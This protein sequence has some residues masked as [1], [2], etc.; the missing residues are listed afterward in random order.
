MPEPQII[1]FKSDQYNLVGSLHLPEVPHPPFIIGC[2]GLFADRQSPKQ[3]A[4]AETCNRHGLAYLRFDHRGCGQS[5]GDFDTVTS[6]EG[7]CTDLYHAIRTMQRHPAIGPFRGLFG[8]SFGG[9]VVL[10]YSAENKVPKLVTYAAPYSDKTI[11]RRALQTI[12]SQG[13]IHPRSTKS[14]VFDLTIQLGLIS[15]ILVV[16]GQND[17]LVPASHAVHIHAL[18]Q[19]P[20]KLIIQPGGDH[21]MSDP[22]LQQQFLSHFLNWILND[23]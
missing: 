1:H 21:R 15:N 16:H 23:N 2:H 4:L 18:A 8:S 6:L 19:H 7:R 9:T 17:E 11:M 13:P 14:L 22:A 3:V 20:K 12:N 10:A 5:Q